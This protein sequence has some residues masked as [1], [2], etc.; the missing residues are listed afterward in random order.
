MNGD[1]HTLDSL[2]LRLRNLRQARKLT[3]SDVARA[4][5][6]DRSHLSKIET[7][8]DIP[9]RSALTGL[10]AFFGVSLDWL[11]TGEESAG[12]AGRDR[13]TEEERVLLSCW[14]ALPR[15]EAEPLLAMLRARAAILISEET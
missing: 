1:E 9:G 3:Q 11:L 10:A 7:G 4:V 15:A 13:L 12:A 6:V 5:G 2:A 8:V 14:R